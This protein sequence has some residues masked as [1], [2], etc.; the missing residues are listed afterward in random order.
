MAARL[1]LVTG[2]T[3]FLGG[4]VARVLIGEGWRVRGLTRRD[5]SRS[6]LLEGLPLEFVRGDLSAATDLSAAATGCDAIL[7]VA[8]LVKARTLEEYREVNF[9]GTERLIRAASGAAPE[10]MFVLVSSQAAAGP[11][12]HGRPVVPGD[13]AR[14]VSWYGISK[15]EGE[16]VVRQAW[17]GPWLVL[18]PGVIYGAGDRA[19]LTYFRMAAA[20]WLPVPAAQSHIQI[21]S[22]AQ[23]SMAVARAGG[24]TDLDRRTAFLC[25]P[26]P[27]TVGALAAQI[28]NFPVR[29]PRLLRVPDAMVKTLGFAET[30]REKLT[31]SS[32]PF[33]ADKARELLAGEWTCE[34]GL[35]RE[36]EIP[37][38][39]PLDL[40]LRETW[41]WYSRQGWLNL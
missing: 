20:G 2:V 41:N 24:R 6:P 28:A 14:P 12:L 17:K 27:I 21:G 15:L 38:P 40:G 7:H 4:H 31:G 16:A 11:A 19:L 35:R 26:E 34:A 32:R 5:P 39:I 23:I 3:G 37:P 29:R 13:P 33:N 1:A 22:A 36:L 10:A 9:R 25:D 8:G 18:R 30:L